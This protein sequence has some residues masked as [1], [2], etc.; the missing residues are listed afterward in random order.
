MFKQLFGHPSRKKITMAFL[1]DL[2]RRT[3]EQRIVDLQYENTEWVKE[4]EDGKTSRLDVLVFTSMGERINIEIQMSDQHNMPERL[5]YYWAKLF[6]SS[7]AAGQDYEELPPTIM[8]AILNY[9]LFPHETNH[10][11]TIFHLQEESEH[12]TWS[13]HIEFHAFDLTKFMLNWKIYRKDMKKNPPT[14][15]PW[16]MMLSATDY[17]TKTIDEELFHELEELA[18]NEQEVRAAL[19]EWETL[20]ANKENKALY[21]ARLK[22]LRDQLSNLRGERRIGREEGRQEGLLQGKYEIAMEMLRSGLDKKLIMTLTKL[23]EEKIHEL[24]EQ[25]LNQFEDLQ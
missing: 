15:L 6:S 1:N 22:Y 12:F 7:L 13:P 9:P 21:E 11:H 18:M 19:I 25:L 16:L 10:F 8:I 2:L 17:Q 3:G 4:T 5:L 20:S 23:S 24:E 14:E